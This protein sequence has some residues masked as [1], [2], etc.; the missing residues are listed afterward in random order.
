MVVAAGAAERE[1]EERLADGVDLLVDDVGQELLLI[2]LGEDLR[3]HGEEPGG[4]DEPRAFPLGHP[5]LDEEV[6]GEVRPQE[7]VDGHV[8]VEGLDHPVAVAPGVA[9]GDVLV[10]AVGVGVADDVEPVPGLVLAVARRGEEAVDHPLPGAGG[11]VGEEGVDLVG[12]GG[13]AGEPDRRAAQQRRPVGDA[14]RH[15]PPLVERRDDER[16][17]RIGDERPVG[18]RRHRRPHRRVHRPEGPLLGRVEGG[19]RHRPLDRS[20]RMGGAGVDPG[21]D[22]RHRLVGELPVGG[23]GERLVDPRDG[24]DEQTFGR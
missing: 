10:E 17:D 8:A 11:V 5:L 1:S 21:L 6:A 4:G 3:P 13:Q 18:R 19:L 23:H 2:P 24:G 9:M 7:G 22:D 20:L 12:G 14:R 15:Q 16:I